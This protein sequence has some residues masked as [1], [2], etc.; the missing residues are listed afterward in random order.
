MSESL[1]APADNLA[2]PEV[3]RQR[4][5]SM[6][7]ASEW[8]VER[9][10]EAWQRYLDTPLPT[11]TSEK[12]RFANLKSLRELDR[13][14]PAP[15]A[16]PDADDL[17]A[18]SNALS[19]TAGKLVLVDDNIA[20]PIEL[21]PALAEQGV[22]FTPLLDALNRYP[23]LVQQYFMAQSPELGSDKFE[24]LHVAM[25]RAGVFLY[26]PKNVEVKEPFA[27]YHWTKQD[28]TAIFP[29]TIVVCE[30]NAGA[31]LVEFQNGA[32]A[33]TEHLVIANAHLYAGNGAKPQH[34]IIQNWNERTIS[35]Q[36]NTSN[37][38]RDVESK[39]VIVNL[40][41]QQARQEIHGKIFGS[42]SN[43]ELYSLGVPRGTQE[44]D[45]RTLQT[46]IAP[47]S[48]S[49]LLYKNAL[50]D[51][52]RTIFSGLIIVEEGAQQTDAYQTNNNLMLSD[53]AEAN[54]LPGLEI[55]AN[56]VKCSHG[57][58]S[59]RIDDSE[60]F[61]FLARGIPRAKAQE[62]MVFGFFEEIVEKFR[63]DELAEYVRGLVQ[64]K[65]AQ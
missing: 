54:S 41:S 46:H 28:G 60:I 56:D 21:D 40:G 15:F 12:W 52:T 38:Q 7:L 50:S 5:Q 57:A 49:D 36:L 1:T 18:R 22:I 34:R 25:L 4:Q 17:V 45:Q 9:Q 3:F 10:Q 27:V 24:A 20:A 55:G 29:H 48:R 42:G 2:S 37:A 44:F 51:E 6:A 31:T 53:K 63:N 33:D 26:V 64:Q 43:V 30:D 16:K 23:E 13:F 19:K 47:N 58:T 65:F 35:F 14:A 61:Y 59:G 11:R 62:L 32:A 39:Q 8:F